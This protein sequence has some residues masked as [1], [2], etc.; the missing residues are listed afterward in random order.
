MEAIEAIFS[1]CVNANV[2]E[3]NEK[4]ICSPQ[5]AMINFSNLVILVSF[6]DY[7]DSSTFL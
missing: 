6:V 2:F 1:V 5:S 7:F 4:N 3:I